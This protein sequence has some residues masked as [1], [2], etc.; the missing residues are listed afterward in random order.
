MKWGGLLRVRVCFL[1]SAGHNVLMRLGGVIAVVVIALVALVAITNPSFNQ[2]ML[3]LI[4]NATAYIING[5][6]VAGEQS[7]I[8]SL[9]GLCSSW[10]SVNLAFSNG[11]SLFLDMPNDSSI[12]LLT[13]DE[14]SNG[15]ADQMPRVITCGLVPCQSSTWSHHQALAIMTWLFVGIP[16]LRIGSLTTRQWVLPRTTGLDW[17]I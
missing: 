11:E 2:F 4:R 3:S 15:V 8:H 10:G 14:F 12:Y 16:T 1:F 17:G 13:S 6:S 9:Q 7:I 5:T